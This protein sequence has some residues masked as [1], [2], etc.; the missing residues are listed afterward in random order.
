MNF[1]DLDEL[2]LFKDHF[3]RLHNFRLLWIKLDPVPLPVSVPVLFLLVLEMLFL[4]V[5]VPPDQ[6]STGLLD[7]GV[8]ISLLLELE[9]P[10][11]CATCSVPQDAY[12]AHSSDTRGQAFSSGI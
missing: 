8:F 9:R 12:N 7:P 4:L 5:R 3:G 6:E 11:G 10:F 1:G 2:R